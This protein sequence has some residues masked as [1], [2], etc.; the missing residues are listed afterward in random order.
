MDKDGKKSTGTDPYVIAKCGPVTTVEALKQA[1]AEVASRLW[2]LWAQP[3]VHRL[4]RHRTPCYFDAHCDGG[5][6]IFA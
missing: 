4:H 3:M 5:R 2:Q 6:S 1:A